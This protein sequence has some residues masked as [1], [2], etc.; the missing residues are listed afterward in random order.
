MGTTRILSSPLIQPEEPAL[1][2]FVLLATVHSARSAKAAVSSS[3]PRS[4]C[5]FEDDASREVIDP[6][7]IMQSRSA[8]RVLRPFS[9]LHRSESPNCCLSF[10][11]TQHRWMHQHRDAGSS[12]G[13]TPSCLLVLQG[14]RQAV[15]LADGSSVR[16]WRKLRIRPRNLDDASRVG[17]TLHDAERG[18]RSGRACAED[19]SPWPGSSTSS[20]CAGRNSRLNPWR[21]SVEPPRGD[22]SDSVSLRGGNGRVGRAGE[23]V[24]VA[25]RDEEPAND[26]QKNRSATL[27]ADFPQEEWLFCRP[28]A[29]PWAST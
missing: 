18:D 20:G 1:S 22:R 21:N 13:F 24:L 7:Q 10:K 17:W 5:V 23:I 25:R 4:I 29:E 19:D 26:D 9:G 14:R 16:R 15:S 27:F 11:Q 3:A 8:L 6:D 12:A 2:G 28:D